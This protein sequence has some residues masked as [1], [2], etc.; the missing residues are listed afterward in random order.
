[1]RFDDG[2]LVMSGLFFAAL[3]LLITYWGYDRVDWRNKS[4]IH[5]FECAVIILAGGA[6]TAYSLIFLLF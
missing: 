1:M 3:G 2:V 5:V 4:I 6:I